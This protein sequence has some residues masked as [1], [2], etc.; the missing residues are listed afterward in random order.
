MRVQR[1]L[2]LA[3]AAVVLALLPAAAGAEFV[4]LGAADQ[5]QMLVGLAFAGP[6]VVWGEP[7]RSELSVFAA[8]PGAHGSTLFSTPPL[9]S[10]EEE[11]GLL[12]LVASPTR[13]AFAYQVQAP[14]CGSMSG[15]CGQPDLPE[16]RSAAAFGGPLGGPFRKLAGD[17]LEN[18]AIGLS[19]EEVVLAE[20][21]HKGGAD[22]DGAYVEDL[23]SGAPA[24]DVGKVGASGV[25]V[26]GSYM[27]NSTLN[28]ITVTTLAGKPVYSV[29]VPAAYAAECTPDSNGVH[30]YPEGATAS[31]GYALAADGT[32]AIASTDP[33]GLYWASPAQPQLQRIAVRLASPLVAIAND[34]IVYLSPVGAHDTQLS[35][36]NL[37]G[38]TRPISSPIDGGG[39]A[40]S[41][42]AFNGTSVAYADHCVYAGSV[43]AAAPSGP[44]DPACEAVTVQP[45]EDASAKVAASGRVRIKL[46]CQYSPC[47]GSLALTSTLDRRIGKGRH[48]KLKRRTVTIATGSFTAIPVSEADTV[49]LRLSRSG[50]RLLRQSDQ[51]PSATVT[52]TVPFA[53]T[54]Q[55]ASATVSLHAGR[56][57]GR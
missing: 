19:G 53:S 40:V 47:S 24:R 5:E 32:L 6:E 22:D 38:S 28:E 21:V 46:S 31:C 20:P 9:S 18:G 27:A 43:P 48:R 25:S 52:A 39:E 57:G 44:P 3:I 11:I 12:D 7:T 42:L 1:L 10:M 34:E 56:P 4:T 33:M 30:R 26:A 41:E 17:S 23:A 29:L 49:S 15:A 50:M 54:S 55:K 16:A 37:S 45:G 36:T 14:Q 13:I 2:P 35:L 51:P 8:I